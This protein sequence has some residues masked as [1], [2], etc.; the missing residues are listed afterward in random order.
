MARLLI[1]RARVPSSDSSATESGDAT[2]GETSSERIV[3]TELT[4]STEG[5]D[6]DCEDVR[7]RRGEDIRSDARDGS[8]A[9]RLWRITRG[10]DGG[11]GTTIADFGDEGGVVRSA[12]VSGNDARG[13]CVKDAGD[14]CG[15]SVE[16]DP[17]SKGSCAPASPLPPPSL[18]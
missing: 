3:L 11:G 8:I 10:E 7:L 1:L 18:A 2:R 13:D 5:R 4:V 9:E 14:P 6:C 17:D 12:S 15:M 16:A